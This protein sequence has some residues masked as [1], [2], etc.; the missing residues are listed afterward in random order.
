MDTSDFQIW[1]INFEFNCK[2]KNQINV[3]C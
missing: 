1:Q 2:I 3:K